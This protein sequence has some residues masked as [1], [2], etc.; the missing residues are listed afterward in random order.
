[1]TAT[2]DVVKLIHAAVDIAGLRNQTQTQEDRLAMSAPQQR[3]V[4][5]CAKLPGPN[6]L[7]GRAASRLL[8]SSG[9]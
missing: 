5:H 6:T 2:S 4:T 7:T 1:M 9:D 3:S 8:R